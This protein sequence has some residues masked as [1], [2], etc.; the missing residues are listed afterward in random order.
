[1]IPADRIGGHQ[2]DTLTVAQAEAWLRRE[3]QLGG[4]RGKPQ[5]RVTCRDYRSR[6]QARHRTD[7]VVK[8]H[9]AVLGSLAADNC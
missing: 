9:V 7:G 8:S 1:M 6:D 3:A 4:H 2:L 5:A